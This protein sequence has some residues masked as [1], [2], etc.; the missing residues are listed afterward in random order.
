MPVPLVYFRVGDDLYMSGRRRS[1]RL[2]NIAH[3]PKVSFLVD[4]GS[5]MFRL[6]QGLLVQGEADLIG[7]D[8]EKLRIAHAAASERGEPEDRWPTETP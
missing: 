5:D 8:G 4:D 7:D 1:Q 6:L 2:A 3:D